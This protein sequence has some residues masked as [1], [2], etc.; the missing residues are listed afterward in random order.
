MLLHFGRPD[1]SRFFSFPFGAARIFNF[2]RKIAVGLAVLLLF[3]FSWRFFKGPNHLVLFLKISVYPV[4]VV[5]ISIHP[6][7][8]AS[9]RQMS[10]TSFTSWLARRGGSR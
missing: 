4:F 5:I 10:C 9:S 1:S 6:H 3:D 2:T 7:G 8:T